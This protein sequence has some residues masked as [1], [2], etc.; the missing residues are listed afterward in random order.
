MGWIYEITNE[1][2]GKK[3]VGQTRIGVNRRFTEHKRDAKR[4]IRDNEFHSILYRAMEKYGIENFSISILE[5]DIPIDLLNER[6]IYWIKKENTFVDDGYGYNLTRGGGQKCVISD[7]TKEK[8]RYNALHGITGHKHI[9]RELVYTKEVREKM[10]KSLKGRKMPEDFKKKVSERMRGR[11]VSQ[12]TRE[13][14]REINIG[15]HHTEKTKKKLSKI[16]EE[17]LADKHNHPFYGK[18]GGQAARHKTVIQFDKNWK[19]IR[20]FGS[21]KEAFEYLGVKGHSKF[22]EAIRNKEMYRGFYWAEKDVETIENTAEEQE[23]S[24]VVGG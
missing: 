18:T 2:N 8:H 6:E 19:E 24:R 3:Y 13:K 7:A 5:S 1:I 9:P 20:T 12:E 21:K 22:N 23:V 16:T 17:R 14:L 10:S 15:R 4:S 11:L